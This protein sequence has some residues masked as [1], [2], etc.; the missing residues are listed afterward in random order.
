MITSATEQDYEDFW[1]D[2]VPETA[3]TNYRQ[4]LKDRLSDII[5]EYIADDALT[6][7]MFFDDV[8]DELRGWVD[9]HEKGLTKSADIYCRVQGFV[10]PENVQCDPNTVACQDHL[11][12][13]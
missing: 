5:S 13:E 6:P 12:E 11:T 3:T 4:F 10:K 1:S 8:V 2:S 9:Y 7:Q